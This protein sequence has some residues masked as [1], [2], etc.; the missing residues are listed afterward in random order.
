[1]PLA[2][3]ALPEL[4]AERRGESLPVLEGELARVQHERAPGV[5]DD[6]RDECAARGLKRNVAPQTTEH[7]DL[8]ALALPVRGQAQAIPV[9]D[10]VQHD[11]LDA[12]AE[13]QLH[14][15]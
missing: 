3:L 9:T 2:L 14:E 7:R 11:D 12:G 15:L 10:R 6:V 8:E 5:D 13:E 1:M 4:L